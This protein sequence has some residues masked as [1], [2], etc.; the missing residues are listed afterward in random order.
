M[1]YG[2]G[3]VQSKR[4]L[5]LTFNPVAPVKRKA[6][7]LHGMSFDLRL[8]QPTSFRI[9][10]TRL[11]DVNQLYKDG[12]DEQIIS[13]LFPMALEQNLV[14]E[15]SFFILIRSLLRT[16][17]NDEALELMANNLELVYE[18]RNLLFE[19]VLLSSKSGKFKQMQ[20]GIAQLDQAFGINGVHSKVLQS[21]LISRSSEAEIRSYRMKMFER[22]KDE[23][24]YEI[25]RAA[26][27]SR[28]WEIAVEI[29]RNITPTARNLFLALR[30]FHR[31]G[32]REDAADLLPRL[33]PTDYSKSQI[34]E[35]IQIGLQVIDKEKMDTWFAA[36]G[37]SSEEIGIELARSRY[38]TALAENDIDA[39]F[40][41]FAVL[42][43]VETFT[44]RQLLTLLRTNPANIETSLQRLFQLGGNNSL[45]LSTI[46]EFGIKYNQ[47]YIGM[48]AFNRL[49]CLALCNQG[50]SEILRHYFTAAMDSGDLRL[51]RSAYKQLRYFH[52]AGEI[53]HE[54]AGYYEHLMHVLGGESSVIEAESYNVEALLLSE[55]IEQVNNLPPYQP[56][57]NHALIVNN[58]I[59][60]GGAERQVVRCLA[61]QRFSKNFVLWNLG[62][63]THSNSFIGS[64]EAMD[65]T[66][67]DYSITRE[68]E[69]DVIPESTKELLSLIPS[70]TPFNPGITTKIQNL[71]TIIEQDRPSTLHLWQDATNV[72]GAISGLIAGSPRIVMSARSLPPFV[73]DGSS[74]PA[75]GPNYYFNN[76]YVRDLYRVLL[77]HERIYLCH[78][79]QNGL[80]KYTEWLGGYEDKM[81]L[82]R[83]GFDFD[84]S[85]IDQISKV[86][87]QDPFVVG[88]V[89]RF[90]DVKQPLLWLDVAKQVLE[91]HPNTLFKMVGDGPML[92]ASIHHAGQ[93][94]VSKNVEFLGYR[95][96]VQSILPT[97]DAFLLTSSIEGL[98]NVLVEAQSNGVPVV[99]TNAGG[100][101][102]TFLP[103]QTGILVKTDSVEDIAHAVLRVIQEPSFSHLAKT[104]GKEFVYNLYSESAMHDQLEHILFGD[105]K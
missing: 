27:N 64:V 98:P 88:T 91:H 69:K 65:L 1:A 36:S 54:F 99:T 30:T 17:Q 63:N 74:F 101:S 13:V 94:G 44:R 25:L 7:T 97:F 86:N 71:A 14:D 85:Q 57:E 59:K 12:K 15:D 32:Q 80:E 95:D 102:E 24:E 33:R 81:V 43:E 104:K 26:F 62:V 79:S 8:N 76:R 42:F 21:L 38:Q 22:Y 70:T 75:K 96:D 41:A 9:N 28:S 93:I 72:L 49:E 10:Y 61:S 45:L 51:L 68:L 37:L 92:D 6:M 40:E 56:K 20:R 2:V 84:E 89:F 50:N 11:P 73:V 82:L 39:A 29:A 83:N 67:Y 100:A 4:G 47:I 103:E 90:V 87:R 55:V 19:F 35:A 3:L 60:F 31:T 52:G 105:L 34:L 16:R 53:L 77:K 46:A 48:E 66:I 23:A 78:N 18:N 5:Y 58:S